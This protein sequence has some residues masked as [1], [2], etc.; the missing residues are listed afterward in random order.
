LSHPLG[1]R[2]QGACGVSVE[3]SGQRKLIAIGAAVAV[4]L[5][6]VALYFALFDR[7]NPV[8]PATPAASAPQAALPADH[9]PVGGPGGGAPPSKHPQ[10][11]D[12]G[13]A[14]RV[15][16]GVKGRWQAVKLKVE[17]R[18]GS[19]PPQIYTVPIGGEVQIPG[20]ALHVQVREFLP[21][22]QVQNAEITSAGNEPSNP[23]VLVAVKDGDRESFRGWLFANFPEMQPFDHPTYRITLVEGIPKR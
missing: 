17:T 6:M 16:D 4:P 1:A 10:V 3:Q 2:I 5:A 11:G 15:P 12:G 13:R 19:A 9:P 14:V 22:L 18:G 23:A 21:A 8:G 20:S 7:P